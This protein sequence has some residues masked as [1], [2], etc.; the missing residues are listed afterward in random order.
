M[1]SRKTTAELT[2][3]NRPMDVDEDWADWPAGWA[4]V[5][6][7]MDSAS[8]AFNKDNN[9]YYYYYSISM[10]GCEERVCVPFA[11]MCKESSDDLSYGRKNLKSK[12]KSI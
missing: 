4:A 7:T 3:Y 5:V 11:T 8:N 2:K 9:N 6:A 12:L 1:A 10:R